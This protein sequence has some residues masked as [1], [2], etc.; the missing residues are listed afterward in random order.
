MEDFK[1]TA[2]KQENIEQV[3]AFI[4]TGYENDLF[5]KWV[6][7]DDDARHGIVTNYYKI[8]L[9]AERTMAHVAHD[10][11]G[12][13]VGATV[14][15]HYDAEE[16]IYDDINEA[17]GI[18]AKNFQAVADKS[19]ANE[20]EDEP[21]YQLVAV[22]VDK[23]VQN[24][25]IGAALL[26]K[27]IDFCDEWGYDTYLEASTPY[28]QDKGLY[29]KFSYQPYGEIMT[30][31][32]GVHLY[33]LRRSVQER[34]VNIGRTAFVYDEASF[35]HD[36]GSGA[37]FEAAGGYIEA[38]TT[39]I[40]ESPG[41]KRR[42]KNLLDR[43]GLSYMLRQVKPRIASIEQLS[44]AHNMSHI[45]NVANLS[46]TGGMDCGDG[47]IVGK[48]SF[49]IARKSV[50]AAVTAV[51]RVL[52][53]DK[54][55]NAYALTRPPGHHAEVGRG[56]GFCIF[57]NVVIAAKYAQ[58]EQGI[59]KIAIIDWDAH[60]GNGTE[61]AFYDDENVLFISLH[62][63]NLEPIGRG[64]MTDTGTGD[65]VGTTI[66]IPLPAASGD[67]VYKY[68]FEEIVIPA[69]EKFAPELILVSAGQDGSIFD[70]LAR[71][72]LTVE[73]YRY[74]AK[75]VKE[76][77]AKCADDRLVL[78]HEGGYCET[79]VPFCTH[80]IIEE[81]CGI[82]T[83]VADPFIYAMAGT[84]YDKM[85]PHQKQQVDDIREHHKNLGKG[86]I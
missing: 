66:N 10:S 68:A 11:S 37:L 62:Q 48:G 13:L 27:Q 67:A 79:Y 71:M 56:M 24:K 33:P 54:I 51:E 47:A 73:G 69:V 29:G 18:Y 75:A 1:I 72:M 86:L 36:T 61:D 76:L 52:T 50:G 40:I 78:V 14:W 77:A 63:D 70:P 20:P 80:A 45:R 8:Y 23:T 38:T 34:R 17:A 16:S 55:K 4:A 57:N 60:H 6:V 74:M 84:G 42:I 25:G 43:S 82:P 32:E 12:N 7:P 44:Y 2:F 59:K 41:S 64:K 81:L 15:L 22:V 65:A 30:F 58:I 83:D 26:D 28:I 39:G 49:D 35:W 53:N 46:E 19:H 31:V 5:F 9:K 85:L 3:A 21:F